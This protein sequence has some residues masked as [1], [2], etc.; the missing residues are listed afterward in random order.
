MRTDRRS[1]KNIFVTEPDKPIANE[2]EIKDKIEYI[3][4]FDISALETMN[5]VRDAPPNLNDD[6]KISENFYKIAQANGM[7]Y[8]GLTSG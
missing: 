3:G 4:C 8:V 7:S 2:S 1:N 6:N 5:A